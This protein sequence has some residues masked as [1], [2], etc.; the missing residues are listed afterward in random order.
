MRLRLWKSFLDLRFCH[1]PR[2]MASGILR[3]W[4]CYPTARKYR[5]AKRRFPTLY[6]Q[7]SS[8]RETLV[9]WLRF[10]RAFGV[11][12]MGLASL[13]GCG[14]GDNGKT[15]GDPESGEPILL[16]DSEG[17]A[18]AKALYE[19]ACASCHDPGAS[20]SAPSIGVREDWEDRSRIWVAVLEEHARLG[21]LEMPAKG[22]D[23]ALTDDE[24]AAA[25]EYMLSVTYPELPLD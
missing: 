12:V 13:V 15:A 18:K 22:G 11:C 23:P 9:Y 10:I 16:W 17:R 24:V 3:M 19:R 20:E 2:Q 21:Y 6:W 7:G 1:L 8:S 25:S 14:E 5:F 4:A